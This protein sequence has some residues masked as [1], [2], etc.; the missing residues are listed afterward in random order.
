M[1]RELDPGRGTV[2]VIVSES[3]MLPIRAIVEALGVKV[4][5]EPVGKKI[6]IKL[7]GKTLDMWIGKNTMK[8]NNTNKTMDV[9]PVIINERTMVP[10]RFVA[11]NLGYEV[12]WKQETKAVIIQ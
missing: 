1:R 10:V 3:T 6:T 8:I 9:A 11:E 5:Y 2:P 12:Q 7:D 4:E